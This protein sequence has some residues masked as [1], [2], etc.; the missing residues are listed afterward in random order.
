MEKTGQQKRNTQSYKVVLYGNDVF[1]A[2]KN[3]TDRF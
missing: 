3:D 2:D 1:V